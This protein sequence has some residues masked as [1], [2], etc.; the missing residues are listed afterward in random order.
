LRNTDTLGQERQ[1]KGFTA[2]VLT[3]NRKMRHVLEKMDWNIKIK[4][5]GGVTG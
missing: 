1:L 4:R 3:E 5:P 2:D